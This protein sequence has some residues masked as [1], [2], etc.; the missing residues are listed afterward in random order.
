MLIREFRMTENEIEYL[1]QM[2]TESE[3]ATRFVDRLRM[4]WEKKQN[5][6]RAI[7]TGRWRGF[8]TYQKLEGH[9]IDEEDTRM[10]KEKYISSEEISEIIRNRKPYGGLA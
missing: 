1:L 10:I 4:D 2:P 8:L 9:V 5:T 6:F 7:N 3:E